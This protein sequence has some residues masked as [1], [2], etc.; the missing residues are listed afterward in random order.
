MVFS[1]DPIVRVSDA[2]PYFQDRRGI[3]GTKKEVSV[4]YQLQFLPYVA[5]KLDRKRKN[6]LTQ[7]T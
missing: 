2:C 3:P 5:I 4:A 6:Q 1:S 7:N